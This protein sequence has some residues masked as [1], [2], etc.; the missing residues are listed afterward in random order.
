MYTEKRSTSANN[1][2]ALTRLRQSWGFIDILADLQPLLAIYVEPEQ[3]TETSTTT[4]YISPMFAMSVKKNLRDTM[5]SGNTKKKNIQR[6]PTWRFWRKR[7][8]SPESNDAFVSM[9]MQQY[10]SHTMM[11]MCPCVCVNPKIIL[12]SSLRCK[13][14]LGSLLKIYLNY[15]SRS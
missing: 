6:C 15:N 5:V 2:G 13:L 14:S 12:A 4:M 7:L 3:L 1:Q 9:W 10:C 8:S 11:T